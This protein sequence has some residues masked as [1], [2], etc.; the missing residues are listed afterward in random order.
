MR[1]RS[2]SQRRANIA[3]SVDRGLRAHPLADL[4]RANA[5][6]KR[7]VVNTALTR[8]VNVLEDLAA[9]S[10]H[11]LAGMVRAEAERAVG[12]RALA[13]IRVAV[14]GL[15]E[16]MVTVSLPLV[17]WLVE[18]FLGRGVLV[19]Q[20]YVARLSR[21]LPSLARL[22]GGQDVKMGPI[23]SAIIMA[24][25]AATVR[26][27]GQNALRY[28]LQVYIYEESDPQAG[29]MCSLCASAQCDQIAASAGQA[30]SGQP[31]ADL[32]KRVMRSIDELLVEYEGRTLTAV[33]REIV[34]GPARPASGVRGIAAAAAAQMVAA[35]PRGVNVAVAGVAVPLYGFVRRKLNSMG[36][37]MS[38]PQYVSI[39][40]R[41]LKTVR[42]FTAGK[43]G[44]NIEPMLVRCV[45]AAKP[46]GLIAGA[47]RA[48]YGG[49]VTPE[50]CALCRTK[51]GAC[52]RR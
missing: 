28:L 21:V 8:L 51:Y 12:A 4:N 49:P 19:D 50:F 36:L 23:L 30:A 9:M 3:R 34:F 37:D 45:A 13:A 25:D 33:V 46:L 35:L 11:S 44:V 18:R 27:T 40:A 38:M 16:T 5:E 42:E 1:T 2:A 17:R 47:V 24:M 6:R 26:Q 31:L 41:D 29:T 14:G 15:P 52:G 10:G 32:T 39:I 20:A 48:R 43:P 7:M 22:L